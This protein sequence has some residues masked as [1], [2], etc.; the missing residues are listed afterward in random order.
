MYRRAS[1]VP[2]A[3]VLR[4]PTI[5]LLLLRVRVV[6]VRERSIQP[7]VQVLPEVDDRTPVSSEAGAWLA[8]VVQA[9]AYE[10]N[11]AQCMHICKLLI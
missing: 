11:V 4:G 1:A 7:R 5:L 3:L 2:L 10:E 8:G 6:P 9:M